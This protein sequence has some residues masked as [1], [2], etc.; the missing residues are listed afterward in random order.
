MMEKLTERR[1]TSLSATEAAA[2]AREASREQRS[3]SWLLR[4]AWV[5]Y[6]T[7]KNGDDAK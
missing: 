5:A 6:I 4:R 7:R 1:T 3:E 2:L